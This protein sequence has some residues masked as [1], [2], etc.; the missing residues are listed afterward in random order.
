MTSMQGMAWRQM[1]ARIWPEK[2][3]PDDF[4]C[5]VCSLLSSLKNQG[6]PAALKLRSYEKL[7]R[8]LLYSLQR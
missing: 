6:T 4:I 8:R 2:A 3:H 5:L 1:C 7:Y